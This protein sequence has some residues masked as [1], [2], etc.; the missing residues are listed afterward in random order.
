MKRQRA[1]DLGEDN[2]DVLL[3]MY[4]GG[5][6]IDILDTYVKQQQLLLNSITMA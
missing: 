6:N 5:N 1:K 3:S 4:S 2:V